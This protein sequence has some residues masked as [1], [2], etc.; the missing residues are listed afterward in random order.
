MEV[1]KG[2]RQQA[3]RDL[4]DSDGHGGQQYA[5]LI[6]IDTPEALAAC[7]NIPALADP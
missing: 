6:D 2:M 7:R 3:I 4:L 1:M 5:P